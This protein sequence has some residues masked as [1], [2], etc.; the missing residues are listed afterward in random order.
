VYKRQSSGSQAAFSAFV[1]ERA[2]Y[3]YNVAY[4]VTLNREAAEDA[5]QNAF[6]KLWE[7]RSTIQ[8]DGNLNAWVYRVVVN[9]AIDDK[10]RLKFAQLD[11]NIT[12]DNGQDEMEK[13][14]VANKIDKILA[15]LP[16]RQR[17]AMMMVYYDEMPQAEVAEIMGVKL[18]A[19]ESLLSRAKAELKVRIK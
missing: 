19:L 7:K 14:D 13:A 2:R 10:R 15:T 8:P 6:S 18:K 9:M 17:A 3:Y 5:V 16:P 12:G 1:K 11:E 4:R